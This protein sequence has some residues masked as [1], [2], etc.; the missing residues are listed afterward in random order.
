[1]DGFGICVTM[2]NIIGCCVFFSDKKKHISEGEI[3][4]IFSAAAKTNPNRADLENSMVVFA[5]I[6]F[7]DQLPT[8]QRISGFF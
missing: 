5:E 6:K 3:R 7:D 4:E 2:T 8:L 1:L